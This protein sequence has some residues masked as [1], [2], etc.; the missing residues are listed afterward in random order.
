MDGGTGTF[1]AVDA[2]M[3][4]YTRERIL[5]PR[6]DSPVRYNMTVSVSY[7][8]AQTFRYSRVINPDRSY[9]SD[10]A[11]LSDGT[12]VL[13]Y[14]C[15]GDIASFSL[16]VY[17]CRFNLEWLT[18]GRDSLAR[19]PRLK[20]KSYDL[21]HGARGGSVTVVRELMAHGGAP[22]RPDR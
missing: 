10:L 3:L 18:Q 17:I 2:G 1:N 21:A 16:R 14:G 22:C 5:L 4:S 7:D 19:R 11:R 6:P 9:Y 13:I 15:D 8:D 20:S 12:I